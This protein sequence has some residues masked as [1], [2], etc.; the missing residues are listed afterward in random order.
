MTTPAA[1][2]AFTQSTCGNDHVLIPWNICKSGGMCWAIETV[3]LVILAMSVARLGG[4]NY[5]YKSPGPKT[6][7]AGWAQFT[8]MAAGFALAAQSPAQSNV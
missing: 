3:R 5:Y 7:R 4:W 1:P 6:M 2:T 8:A